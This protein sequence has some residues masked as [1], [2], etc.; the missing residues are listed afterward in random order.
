MA[1]AG[2]SGTVT[3]SHHRSFIKIGTYAVKIPQKCTVL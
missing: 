1:P 2:V 3:I